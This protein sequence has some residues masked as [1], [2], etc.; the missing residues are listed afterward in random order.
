M[1]ILQKL[2]NLPLALEQ[3]GAYINRRQYSFTR[4]LKEF[5]DSITHV[6]NSKDKRLSGKQNRSVFASWELSFDAVQKENPK[7][8]DLLLLCGYLDN[9][10]IPEELLRK[11]LKL[12]EKGKT[13]KFACA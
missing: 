13:A 2:G 10:D 5:E 8:A 1:T 12:A 9:D 6:L 7:A 3:V 4:Y 11:G